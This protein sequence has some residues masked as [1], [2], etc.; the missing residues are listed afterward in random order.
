M[1]VEECDSFGW[2]ASNVL[3]YLPGRDLGLAGMRRVINDCEEDNEGMMMTSNTG[4][5]DQAEFSSFPSPQTGALPSHRHLLFMITV[6]MQ[7]KMNKNEFS[8]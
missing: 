6:I 8:S 2:I 5:A 4:E 7:I 3:H 1:G